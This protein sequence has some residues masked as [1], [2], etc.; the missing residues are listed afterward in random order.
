MAG[1]R[2]IIPRTPQRFVCLEHEFRVLHRIACY[3]GFYPVVVHGHRLVGRSHE[4]PFHKSLLGRCFGNKV[5]IGEQDEFVPKAHS[6]AFQFP[7]EV[8]IVVGQILDLVQI[9]EERACVEEEFPVPCGRLPR[10]G[11]GAFHDL[12]RASAQDEGF[13]D[14]AL[15]VAL[16]DGEDDTCCIVQI[17]VVFRLAGV[18]EAHGR[19]IGI[20]R[21]AAGGHI[22]FDAQ[23][24]VRQSGCAI[25][26]PHVPSATPNHLRHVDVLLERGD[27]VADGDED[28]AARTQ[29]R[30]VF[31]RAEELLQ[32][33]LLIGQQKDDASDPVLGRD[34]IRQVVDQQDLDVR[35]LGE[36]GQDARIHQF[37]VLDLGY[38][39]HDVRIEGR[40]V[41]ALYRHFHGTLIGKLHGHLL[42]HWLREALH[43]LPCLERRLAQY[44]TLPGIQNL[45][46]LTGVHA[47]RFMQPGSCVH[48]PGKGSG[49]LRR[50]VG[51]VDAG[52]VVGDDDPASRTDEQVFQRLRRSEERRTVLQF[53]GRQE[54]AA[55]RRY[56][57]HAVTPD[58]AV[59]DAWRD[60]DLEMV[61][62][63]HD[64]IVTDTL[65][66]DGALSREE[67]RFQI[68]EGESVAGRDDGMRMEPVAFPKLADLPAQTVFPENIAEFVQEFRADGVAHV[69][70]QDLSGRLKRDVPVGKQDVRTADEARFAFK[71]PPADADSSRTHH[72]PVFYL[73]V[74]IGDASC[75]EGDAAVTEGMAAVDRQVEFRFDMLPCHAGKWYDGNRG[76][77]PGLGDEAI[78]QQV[79]PFPGVQLLGHRRGE[80]VQPQERWKTGFLDMG[81]FN[82]LR[83]LVGQFLHRVEGSDLA[84]DV[85]TLLF[86]PAGK[87]FLVPVRKG[88][89]AGPFR[90]HDDIR[91]DRRTDHVV[92]DGFG[93]LHARA[94]RQDLC[95]RNGVGGQDLAHIVLCQREELVRRLVIGHFAGGDGS[96]RHDARDIGD[97]GTGF[98]DEHTEGRARVHFR[99]QGL[100]GDDPVG[101]ARVFRPQGIERLVSELPDERI[102]RGLGRGLLRGLG[103][104]GIDVW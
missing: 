25:R 48:T 24:D 33:L 14:L 26:Y 20:P 16:P 44:E 93:I 95:I 21:C 54:E 46:C 43:W 60:A 92:E 8:V 55:L 45:A 13:E 96:A 39:L 23:G 99:G 22:R 1:A 12:R 53:R 50:A 74:G 32:L 73:A 98:H 70:Q 5:R 59:P 56:G 11:Q 36:G 10:H 7:A 51:D 66:A 49:F 67:T 34:E 40:A 52:A 17:G 61:A 29:Q 38:L 100:E 85:R 68:E 19:S 62:Q 78:G 83:Q 58:P 37:R 41:V 75:I 76:V 97:V 89:R 72:R 69:V 57:Q 103:H 28:L 27:E 4:H 15:R 86:Q 81:R 42:R 6:P 104:V 101:D 88:R 3:L 80:S 47:V 91:R 35:V 94:F 77:F 84:E 2:V 71:A 30:G 79:G 65:D 31:F 64:D 63:A 90:R 87:H 9:R 18:P 102:F 82:G